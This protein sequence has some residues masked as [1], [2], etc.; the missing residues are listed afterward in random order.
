MVHLHY[1]NLK[2]WKPIEIDFG[3][4]LLIWK[5]EAIDVPGQECYTTDASASPQAHPRL[6]H[7]H[8]I[9]IITILHRQTH[10]TLPS[11]LGDTAIQKPL[12]LVLI[13]SLV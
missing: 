10:A 2:P 1:N 7:P 9:A 6:I 5:T 3:S 12:K 4:S 11:M 8:T 13:L